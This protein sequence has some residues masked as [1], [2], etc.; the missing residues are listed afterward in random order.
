VTV[1]DALPANASVIG[2]L[3]FTD[4]GSVYFQSVEQNMQMAAEP[5]V[6]AEVQSEVNDEPAVSVVQ[7]GVNDSPHISH[8][9][10]LC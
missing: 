9:H 5:T 8:S 3:N 2:Y 10:Y 4:D 1:V 7:S 6:S